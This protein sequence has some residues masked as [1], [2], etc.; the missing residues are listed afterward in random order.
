[1]LKIGHFDNQV[2]LW[3]QRHSANLMKVVLGISKYLNF[4][5]SEM[6]T[7]QNAPLT[8]MDKVEQHTGQDTKLRSL[9]PCLVFHIVHGT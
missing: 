8:V 7:P 9:E 4:P 6:Y 5:E 3:T 2:D 1:M